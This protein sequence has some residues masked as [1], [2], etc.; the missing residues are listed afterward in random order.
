MCV[1]WV[2]EV[3]KN[4]ARVRGA[5]LRRSE[6]LAGLAEHYYLI[7]FP[8]SLRDKSVATPAAAHRP[9]APDP[10]HF[11]MTRSLPLNKYTCTYF[12]VVL[13]LYFLYAPLILFYFES[14]T[15]TR[16]L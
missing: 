13:Q 1:L 9:E 16:F 3:D 8:P 5:Q 6:G 10:R 14:F 2:K 11:T 4:T 15:A 7:Y 12:S